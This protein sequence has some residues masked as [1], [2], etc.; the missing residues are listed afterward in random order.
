MTGTSE[1]N[2]IAELDRL[3]A[4][5]LRR[6]AN[7]IGERTPPGGKIDQIE[8]ACRNR[9]LK[10]HAEQLERDEEFRAAEKQVDAAFSTWSDVFKALL[11]V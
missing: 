3:I 11:S 4:D 6:R 7:L 8:T 1:P 10:P 2:S 5:A 9:G